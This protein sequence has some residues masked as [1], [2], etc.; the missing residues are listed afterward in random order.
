[1]CPLSALRLRLPGQDGGL[2][3]SYF[4]ASHLPDPSKRALCQELLDEFGARTSRVNEKTGEMIH[5]CL[6]APE[7][8]KDQDRNPTAS[9]NFQKLTYN[10][11]GCGSSGGLLWFIATCRGETSVAARSWLEKT[12]GL[13][14]AVLELDAM[15]RFLD[16]IYA[17]PAAVP[18]P[19]YSPRVLDAWAYDHPYMTE[20]RHVGP[21]II[22]RFRVGWD[23]NNDRVVIP[24]FWQG[25]LVGWQS[26]MMP[27]QWRSQE[28]TPKPPDKDG[29]EVVDVHSGN[30]RAP[31]YYSSS[32]FPKDS[33]IFN[34]DPKA[35]EAVVV[36]S[37][38]SVL[39]HVEHRHFEGLFGAKVTDLQIRR[40]VKH[41]R[42]ILWMDNDNA[43][44]KAIEGKPEVKPTKEKP[45]GEE[46]VPGMAEQLARYVEVRIVDSPWSQ[47]AGD[48][49]TDA[50]MEL[51]DGAVPWSIWKRPGVLYCF[52]CKR[53]AHDGSCTG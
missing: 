51:I 48:L 42:V 10:C 29:N 19:S 31:K 23:P 2:L 4:E 3:V 24:H 28:W 34:Y 13:G 44:W 15:L 37:M 11:L 8:H 20:A 52:E 7:L 16:N 47:D 53:K 43:G 18:I 9:L 41:D 36:E 32:D 35:R 1:V 5:G 14:G 45:Q 46:R 25:K 6:V 30:P 39:R 21:E 27:P 33:T 17:R 26:R 50:A 12:A 49:P 40:L 22:K 38:L